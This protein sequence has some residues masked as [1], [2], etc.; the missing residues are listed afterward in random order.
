LKLSITRLANGQLRSIESYIRE[1][2][3]SAAIRVGDAIQSAFEIL[4]RHPYAGRP[5]HSP[6][7]REKSVTRYPYVIIYQL[8]PG[9][10]DTVVILGVYHTAQG[11]RKT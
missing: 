11:E 1:R 4:Q 3:P 10:P 5:G 7:T 9:M 6:D 2:N 8:P